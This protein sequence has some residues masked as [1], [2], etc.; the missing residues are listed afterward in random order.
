MRSVIRTSVYVAALLAAPVSF[1][2]D[3]DRQQVQAQVLDH[4]EFLCANCLLGASDYYYCFAVDNKI[5]IGY[6]RTRVLNWQDETKNYLTGV[7]GGWAA[8]TAPGQTVP[9]SYDD[10][11]IW[12]S[13]EVKPARQ[14]LWA[15]MKGFG[16]WVIRADSKQVRLTQ[17]PLRDIF[18]NND[19]CR[20]ADTAKAH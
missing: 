4:A 16:S 18:T 20:N 19:R 7:H 10:K 12:V 2:A 9:I 3:V 1:G 5:L 13:R 14:G 6:Q 11:H 15:H 8:W 17:S